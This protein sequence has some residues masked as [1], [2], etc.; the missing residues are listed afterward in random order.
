[1][2]MRMTTYRFSKFIQSASV[3]GPESTTK[4]TTSYGDRVKV[5]PEPVLV[6]GLITHMVTMEFA[7]EERE[8]D[9]PEEDE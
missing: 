5:D 6:N 1:M 9:C 3:V 8:E 7:E 4:V 2:K